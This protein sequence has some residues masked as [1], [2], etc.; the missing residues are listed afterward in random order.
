LI[1][2]KDKNNKRT[3]KKEKE[4]TKEKNKEGLAS[5]SP[6]RCSIDR[7]KTPKHSR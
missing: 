7:C 5:T 3:S 4:H 6:R 1:N 2:R